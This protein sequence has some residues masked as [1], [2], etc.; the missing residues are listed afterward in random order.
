L[1]RFVLIALAISG[2]IPSIAQAE[3]LVGRATVVDGDTLGI[4]DQRIRLHGIDAPE[5]SQ[6]CTT[7]NGKDWRCGQKAANALSEKIGQR[8]VRCVGTKRDRWKRL[9]AVCFVGDQDLN[10]WLVRRGWAV[11]YRKYSKDYVPQEE[12][13]RRAKVGVW[14]GEFVMPWDWRKSKRTKAK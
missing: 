7:P 6:L 8:N 1:T 10:G 14:S 9:I 5:S 12:R 2:T 11:A 3:E 4:R 13:A